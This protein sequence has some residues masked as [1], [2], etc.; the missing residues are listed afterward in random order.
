MFDA[1]GSLGD[2]AVAGIAFCRPLV[3]GNRPLFAALFVAGLAGGASHCLGMCGPFVLAQTGA[4]LE[5]VSAERMGELTR[6]GGGALLPYHFGRITTYGALGA[7]AGTFAGG[8]DRLSGHAWLSAAALIAA[9]LLFLGVGAQRLSHAIA[10]RALFAGTAAFGLARGLAPLFVRPLGWRGYALGLLL[11]FL[12][13]GLLYAALAAA[14][15]AGGALAGAIA[16]I[17]FTL[18][19]MPG[20]IILGVLGELAGRRWSEAA[21]RFATIL[22]PLNALLLLAL[23]ARRLTME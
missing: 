6:L 17:A 14:S 23:A 21:G 13:C 20:L 7:I 10:G 18:G 4:R 8:V 22:M 19:T 12:P 3:E 15:A 2:L 16:M 11:G 9:A 1:L 5:T